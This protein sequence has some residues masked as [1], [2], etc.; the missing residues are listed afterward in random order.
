MESKNKYSL[1]YEFCFDFRTKADFRLREDRGVHN[2]DIYQVDSLRWFENLYS[3]E[4]YLLSLEICSDY[5]F[6]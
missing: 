2:Y 4:I 1:R 6:Q 5:L 3:M